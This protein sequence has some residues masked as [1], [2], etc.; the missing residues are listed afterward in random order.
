MVSL[1]PG[2]A[3]QNGVVQLLLLLIGGHSAVDEGVQSPADIGVVVIHIPGAV[4]VLAGVDLLHGC[5]E[6][7]LVFDA[8]FLDD[9]HIGTVQSA[10]GHSAVEHQLHVAGAGGLRAGRGDLLGNVGGGDDMLGVGAVVVLHEHHFHLIVHLRIIV[11]HPGD[12]VNIADNRL[13][14]GIARGGLGAEDKCG[15]LE[16]LQLAILQPEV[17]I[18]N[19][20]G[21]HQLPLVLVQTLY[22]HIEHK[23]GV[24][25]NALPLVD[26]LAQLLLLLALDSIEL[27]YHVVVD[28][29]L[30]L[31]QQL[32]I[33]QEVAADAVLNQLGQFRIAQAHPA[34]GGHTIGLVLETIGEGGIPLLE[35]VVLQDLAVDLG[36]AVDIAAYIDAEVC[37]VCGI[38]LDNKQ[39]GVFLLQ[40]FIDAADDGNDLRH[41]RVQQIQIPLFQRLAH[42]GVIGVRE[43][44]L[45]NGKAVLKVHSLQHQ[46]TNQLGDGHGGVGIVELHGVEISKVAQIV[47]VGALIVAQDILQGS[48]R[49]HILL[50][51]TQALALPG[52]VVGIQYAGNILGLVLLSQ[53]TQ[54]VLI[55]EG[56]KVQLLLSFALPQTQGAD[57][58]GTVANDGHIVGNGQHGVVGEKDLHGVVVAAVGPGIAE[59]GP[60][61]GSFYLGAVGIKLLLEQ[62]EAV[63]QA[64]ATEGNVAAG[65][66]IQEAGSQ[67]AQTAIAQSSILDFLQ[68][69]QVNALGSKQLLHFV[70]NTQI[71]QVGIYQTADQILSG[72]VV[73]LPLVH[74]H[75]LA[76]VP[77]VGNGHHYGVAQG[78]MQFL[79]GGVLQGHIVGVLQLGLRPLQ[80][81]QTI[82]T[83]LLF[84]P[85]K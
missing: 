26:H 10:Q 68:A 73:C 12:T 63:A 64:V 18:H 34:A 13:G 45:G 85:K 62:A 69:G 70:Q 5:A 47:A 11:N 35:A 41:N 78:L 36:H 84:T 19:G 32:Q 71:V 57:V 75:L 9:L 58:F 48:G 42:N 65:R 24:Q 8:G 2:S 72:N 74:T 44:L 77:V 61:V 40:L 7:I 20:Q 52:G 38:V 82:I 28:H 54:I 53:S 66:G 37:H 21:V 30:Q 3:V 16:V 56:V 15:G 4:I 49:Q 33:L 59:L 43:G 76:V 80:N 60:V 46:Q 29:G 6:D 23:V 50:L 39:A 55:V 81:V 83:H 51:D 25:L 27:F 31:A 14:T 79:G 22:L 1:V 67:T 17:N